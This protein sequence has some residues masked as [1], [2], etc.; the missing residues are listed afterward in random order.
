MR[1]LSG[2]VPRVFTKDR[3][4]PW[5]PLVAGMP[6]WLRVV[7]CTGA[8]LLTQWTSSPRS[9]QDLV[10]TLIAAHMAEVGDWADIYPPPGAEDA[11]KAWRAMAERHAYDMYAVGLYTYHPYYMSAARPLVNRFS[12]DE[13][14]KGLVLVNRFATA[15]VAFEI[16][17]MLAITGLA[18][19]LL[20]T[21]L[22]AACSPVISAIQFGQNSVIALA[23][24]MAAL[25]LWAYGRGATSL[26][27]GAGLAAMAWACKP[28]CGVLL[29]FLLLF[30]SP[31]ASVPAVAAVVAVVIG[32][33]FFIYPDVLMANYAAFMAELS[34]ITIP[35]NINL[36]LLI[37]L[38]RV[39]DE[40][41]LG[42]LDYFGGIE[43][44]PALRYSA[45]GAAALCALLAA[46]AIVKRRPPAAWITAA[47]L[48]LVLLPFGVVWT[49]YFVF[50]L[51]I[52]VLASAADHDSRILRV[53]ALGLLAQ[54]VLLEHW[55][56]V[57]ID[58]TSPW[59]FALPIVS[60]AAV[61]VMALWLGPSE[62]SSERVLAGP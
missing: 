13:L 32:L 47:G 21:L 25:R 38:E 14:R 27:S 55:V 45:T 41:L 30:R 20:L 26:V 58:R 5:S 49:H 18:G 46:I 4:T 16:A 62:P 59:P 54:L 42:R 1:E 12:L 28:W 57:E 9:H 8:L 40:A 29:P 33:P 36:S 39:A 7:V 61:S 3:L 48:G 37:S 22:L 43:P 60:V 50:A 17:E 23:L 6:A 52:A 10:P 35:G 56:N 44:K 51:P 53:F 15:W 24:S 19:Q 2:R 11:L 34:R 31:R